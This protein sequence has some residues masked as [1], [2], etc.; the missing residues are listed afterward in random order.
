[1]SKSGKITIASFFCLTVIAI[2][3]GIGSFVP[4]EA[5]AARKDAP[6]WILRRS[7]KIMDIDP[8]FGD[9]SNILGIMIH[10]DKENWICVYDAIWDIK[11]RGPWPNIGEE[12]SLYTEKERKERPW[13]LRWKWVEGTAPKRIHLDEN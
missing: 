3:Y 10:F 7:G 6:T 8:L 2:L 1:M 4:S 11:H 9:Y 5:E 13:K 12:G